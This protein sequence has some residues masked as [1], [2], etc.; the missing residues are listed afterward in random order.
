M[1]LSCVIIVV[2]YILNAMMDAIVFGKYPEDLKK[3]WHIL[4]AISYGIPFAWILWIETD[5][6][7][8][9]IIYGLCLLVALKVC[10]ETTYRFFRWVKIEKWDR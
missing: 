8:T 9:F 6:I 10:W 7:K 2:S 1:M 5:N 3:L 4:K